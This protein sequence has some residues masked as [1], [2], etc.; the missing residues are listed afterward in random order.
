M[1]SVAYSNCVGTFEFKD[2]KLVKEKLFSNKEIISNAGKPASE[3]PELPPDW[4]LDFFNQPDYLS[5]MREATLLVTKR[6]MAKSVKQDQL[7][8]Q[9]SNNV[10]EIDKVANN[11]AKRL[12]EWYELY[13]PEFSRSIES[14]EKFAELI[15]NKTK[16]ELLKETGVAEEESMG[17]EIDKK[18]LA[19]V[20]ELAKGISALHAMRAKQAEYVE[21]S[22]KEQL[23]NVEAICGATIGAKLLAIAGSLEKLAMFPASTIQLLGAEK[24]LFRHIKTG[25]KPPKFGVIINHPFVTKAKSPDKGR[26]ARILADKISIAAKIDHFKGEF[27]GEQLRKELEAKMELIY[28]SDTQK[29]QD[30]ERPAG[31]EKNRKNITR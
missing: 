17:A 12:R 2:R 22:M 29:K 9:A 13:N 30:K 21:K 18:D 5:K 4:V 31:P 28:R 15:Q 11:L 8:V 24:A 20:M 25:A 14:H 19:P 23:P 10:E 1:A 3:K 26:V 7:I 6:R 27:R 16:K